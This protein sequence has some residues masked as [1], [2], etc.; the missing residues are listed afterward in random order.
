[1]VILADTFQELVCISPRS[2]IEKSQLP[3]VIHISCQF[4]KHAVSMS[5]QRPSEDSMTENNTLKEEWRLL[6][7]YAVW[8]L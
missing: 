5:A 3:V 1:L 4:N 2:N 6:E 8:L 7:C